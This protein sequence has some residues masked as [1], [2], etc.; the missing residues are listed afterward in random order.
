[1]TAKKPTAL[2]ELQGTARADRA[3]PDEPR[4]PAEL[5][6]RPTW[7]DNDPTT[8]AMFDQVVEY[9]HNMKVSTRVDGIALS[10]LADQLTLYMEM[11]EIIREEGLSMVTPAGNN[12]R[13]PLLTPMNQSLTSIHKLLREYGLT[14]VSRSLVSAVEEEGDEFEDFL[15]GS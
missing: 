1:M 6:D 3:N 13:H 12:V 7:I 8:A 11:R 15:G 2:K 14:A 4:L 10:L 9:V 5:P